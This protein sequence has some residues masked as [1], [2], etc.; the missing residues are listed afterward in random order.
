VSVHIRPFSPRDQREC[1][2]VIL[3]GLAE[4]FGFIDESRNPDLDNIEKSYLAAGNDFYVAENNGQI[5]GTVGLLFEQGHARIV[6][7]S[8]AG[9]HRKQGVATALLEWCVATA[10]KRGL[11][12]IVAFTEP[13][14][15][16]AVGF[17]MASGFEQFGRDDEDIH[18]R[19][20]LPGD[21]GNG[22]V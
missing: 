15:P 1:C 2:R 11:P 22:Y 17:Y 18:L 16:D 14:W 13:H 21:S 6:R 19:L 7:M 12:Q 9:S 10:K 20:S 3:D 5:I 8:V 4:H